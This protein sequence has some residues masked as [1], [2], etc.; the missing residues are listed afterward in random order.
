[1]AF[2]VIETQEQL[3]AV[4]GDRIARAEKKAAENAAKE[5]ADYEDLKKKVTTYEAQLA[6]YGK[7][8]TDAQE[9]AKGHTA[10]VDGL[11]AKIKEYET[12]S[13]KARIAHEVGLPYE[14]ANRLAGDTEEAIRLDAE[15]MA[16]FVAHNRPAA[17]MKSTAEP[18]GDS[19]EQAYRSLAQQLEK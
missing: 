12:A 3:D 13:V 8:L 18:V 16:K 11:K 10:E 2:T 17:P 7:Q 1:M 4:I 6:D 19:K 9:L 15:T 5:Y 14:L